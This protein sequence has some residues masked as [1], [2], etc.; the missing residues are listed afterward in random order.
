MVVPPQRLH[1]PTHH[2]SSSTSKP[3]A[4]AS[5]KVA[6]QNVG[7]REVVATDR[8]RESRQFCAGETA[9]IKFIKD[10]ELK[11]RIASQFS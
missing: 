5:F 9:I 8:R 7:C 6:P 1:H 4:A 3:D 11:Q 10:Y 2:A